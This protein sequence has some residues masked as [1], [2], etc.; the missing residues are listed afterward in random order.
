MLCGHAICGIL[1]RCASG[2]TA[3]RVEERMQTKT[4]PITTGYEILF[5]LVR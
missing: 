2:P 5:T 3:S 4:L 1:F